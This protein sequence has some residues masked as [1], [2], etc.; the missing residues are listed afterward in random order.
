MLSVC[1]D[2]NANPNESI[3]SAIEMGKV[4][5]GQSSTGRNAPEAEG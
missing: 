1:N 2:E 3:D 4:V 5:E